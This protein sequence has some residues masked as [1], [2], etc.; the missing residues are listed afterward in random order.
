MAV[1]AC[2]IKGGDDRLALLP[3]T[4]MNKYNVPNVPTP[5]ICRGSCTSSQP[6]RKAYVSALAA[7]RTAKAQTSLASTFEE[8][9]HR[10][11]VAWSLGGAADCSVTFFPS[12]TDAEY[13]GALLAIGRAASSGAAS[14][15]G[16]GV[17]SVTSVVTCAGEVG[18]ATSA[19]AVGKHISATL[20]S[21]GSAKVG[22]SIFAA[23]SGVS[24]QLEE[25]MLRETS[26]DLRPTDAVDLQVESLIANHLQSNSNNVGVV[27]LVAGCKTGQISPS[28]GLVER[29]QKRFGARVV[30]VM[31]ACQTRM[32]EGALQTF[33]ERGFCVLA[34]GSK[35]YSGPPFSGA[36][37][38]NK[39]LS[40]ELD[41]AVQSPSLRGLLQ[42]SSL[43][44]YLSASMVDQQHL[45][46]L[47]AA[48][49][50]VHTE[51][52]LGVLTRWQMA[53]VHIESYHRLAVADR[54]MLMRGWV[55]QTSQMIADLHTPAVEVLPEALLPI[56]AEAGML[57]VNTILSFRCR[58]QVGGSWRAATA[59]ELRHVHRLMAID[60]RHAAKTAGMTPDAATRLRQRCF[61]AQPV[62]LGKKSGAVLRLAIGALQVVEAFDAVPAS[63]AS[64][65]DEHQ[66]KM[67][68]LLG[69]E[70]QLVLS[71]LVSLLTNW[72][73]WAAVEA[74]LSPTESV[75]AVFR[76]WDE[77]LT[78]A[79]PLSIFRPV[80]RKVGLK[81]PDSEMDRMFASFLAV[82]SNRLGN[83][84]IDYE[85]F[86]D[87]V[88]K[89]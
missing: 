25:V 8:V 68:N 81:L 20:P 41:A 30:P 88:S 84:V 42:G 71:K 50:D 44:E 45:P 36:V 37:L 32:R 70:D 58:V 22:S 79:I 23:E 15:G 65:R 28:L 54:E 57:D 11:R 43:G 3:A 4:G 31:D 1:A 60:L 51:M 76:L 16:S 74:S 82:E 64:S 17:G 40:A 48:V 63:P 67:L 18:S 85:A 27:H 47:A 35:F 83:E 2:I 5:G 9:R 62:V 66:G 12:G 7:L 24:L 29:L 55:A 10:L 33:V 6:S 77:K 13:I 49:P 59:D 69:S 56:A 87:H 78:G 75:K 53:L 80:L 21:G 34:T 73:T 39:A 46:H 26:G 72:D 86:M 52:N 89:L 61:I 38:L 19:A 14:A